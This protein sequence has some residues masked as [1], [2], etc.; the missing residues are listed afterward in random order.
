MTVHPFSRHKPPAATPMPAACGP[1]RCPPPRTTRPPA[2]LPRRY[3]WRKPFVPAREPRPARQ[4]R[5]DN[6][7]RAGS[8]ECP[9][10]APAGHTPGCARRGRRRQQ[11]SGAGIGTA[12]DAGIQQRGHFGNVAVGGE[13]TLHQVIAAQRDKIRAR[14][15]LPNSQR[16]G[17]RSQIT[18]GGKDM[19][20]EPS[21]AT[22]AP[23]GSA[24][25]T[26]GEMI[27]TGTPSASRRIMG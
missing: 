15:Y 10:I 7:G 18:V 23:S 12:R 1:C 24:L 27:T 6:P 14:Q 13:Q 20:I 11:W 4:R 8:G 19:A 26:A 2:T 3:P 5:R 17:R 21:T 16:S 9:V 22:S 25:A